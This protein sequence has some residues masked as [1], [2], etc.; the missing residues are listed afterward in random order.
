MPVRGI[1]TSGR[2]GQQLFPR[3]RRR[4]HRAGRR[5]RLRG[6]GGNADRQCGECG[7]TRQFSV[8]QARLLQDDSDLGDLPVVVAVG[9]LSDGDVD[10]A[11]DAGL[12]EAERMRT[13]GLIAGAFI[14]LRGRHRTTGL[15]A[16]LVAAKQS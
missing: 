9:P 6:R 15:E 3:H 2:G 4:G 10:E 5:R 1:A 13:A 11:L 14:S 7:Q 12:A 16:A 8:A